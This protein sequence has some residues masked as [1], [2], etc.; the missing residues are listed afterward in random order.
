MTR[1]AGR[2]RK[3]SA[4]HGS[5]GVGSGRVKRFSYLADRVRS[6]QECFESHGSGRV[7]SRV[8]QLSRVGSGRVGSSGV[9][10]LMG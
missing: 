9:E 10:K 2:V 1:H 4:S 7:G 6:G 8:I 3:H 5:A